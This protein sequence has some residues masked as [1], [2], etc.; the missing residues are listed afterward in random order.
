MGFVTVSAFFAWQFTS[1]ARRHRS[2][3]PSQFLT[4]YEDVSFPASDGTKLS[5]WF[6][7]CAKAKCA[8]VLLHG[9]GSLRTQMLARARLLHEQ[10]YAVLL[11]DARGHGE[12]EGTHVSMGWFET[13]DLLGA[14]DWLHARGFAECGCIGASQGGA[15]IALAAAQLKHV[16]WVV[17]ESVYPTLENAVDRRFRHLFGLPGRI[18]GLLMIPLAEWRLGVNMDEI[19]P[20]K[21]I[22][23]L[24]CPV[25]VMSGED[26]RNTQPADARELFDHARDPKSFWLVPGAAHVDLYGFA[27][28]DYEQHLLSFIATAH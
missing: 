15:T 11:Y 19:A 25:L 10:G 9:H 2:V 5:G 16:R 26:D 7:P 14:L 6:V 3:E 23:E 22:A 21:H 27:K 28:Q 17:L 12:S 20:A 13:R 18:A 1:P 24:N 8:V 4:A